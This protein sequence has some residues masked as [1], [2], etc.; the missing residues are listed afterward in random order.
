MDVLEKIKRAN[1]TGRGGAGFSTA[2]KWEFVKNAAGDKKYIVCNAAE[3]EPGVMKDGYILEKYGDKVIDGIKLAVNFLKAE[4]AYLYINRAY[5][6]KLAKKLSALINGAPIE[7]F[8]KP[9]SAGYIGG[10]ESALLNAI[11]GRRIEPRLKP[12][13]PAERGLWNAPT[14]VNNAETFYNISLVNAGQFK[15]NRFYTISGDCLNEGVYELPDSL[16]IEKILKTTGNYPRFSFFVQSGGLA[17]G[18]VLNSKQLKRRAGG[19]AGIAVFS[20]AKNNFKSLVKKWLNFYLNESCGQCAAC[21]EG[22]YRLREAWLAEKIDRLM[23]D[24]LLENLSDASFCAL[25][26][27]AAVPIK[28]FIANVLPYYEKN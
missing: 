14:L 24:E 11:E 21:R 22:V 1:L 17:S 27:S 12:P 20:L 23:V 6:K 26:E 16:T 2:K 3:G 5:A 4:K 13:F 10:E 19:A 7:I 25:G 28:S 18:E 9:L 15:N 8:I